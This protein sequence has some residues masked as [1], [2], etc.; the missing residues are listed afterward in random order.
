MATLPVTT[1]ELQVY[2]THLERGGCDVRLDR[3]PCFI[4]LALRCEST[5]EK[6]LWTKIW[7]EHFKNLELISGL[8]YV[9]YVACMI[10]QSGGANSASGSN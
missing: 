6:M 4:L 5:K 9:D 1:T 7:T 8:A 2:L 3:L 10:A